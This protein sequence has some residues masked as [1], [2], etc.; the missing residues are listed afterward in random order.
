VHDQR[1]EA[2]PA[3]GGEDRGD[4][5]IV[6]RDGAEPIDRLCRKGDQPPGAQ[7]LRGA[8]DILLVAPESLGHQKNRR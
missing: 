7:R 6:G 8:L 4:R 1:V 5:P 3:F 2:G